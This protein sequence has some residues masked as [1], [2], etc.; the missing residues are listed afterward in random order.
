M[1]RGGYEVFLSH[2]P[3]RSWNKKFHGS[4]HVYGHVH[5]ALPDHDRS[6]DVGVDC[7]DFKPVSLE[8]ILEYFK[9]EGK[10]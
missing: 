5:G 3:H 9:V 8:Q 2:Y 10:I 1:R 6:T 4:I 7:W